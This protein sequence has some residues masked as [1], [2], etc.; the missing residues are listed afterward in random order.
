MISSSEFELTN[1]QEI[2][3]RYERGE[4]CSR[5][6]R[7]FGVS[8]ETIRKWLEKAGVERRTI[9]DRNRKYTYRHDA[10][11]HFEPVTAYW[12]GLLAADGSVSDRGLVSLELHSKD[13]ELVDG[14]A[15]FIQYTGPVIPRSCRRKS[16]LVSEMI[17]LRVTAPDIASQLLLWGVVPRKTYKAQ[18]ICLREDLECHY[19]RGLFDG[20]GCFH[21]RKNGGL[22]AKI[23]KHPTVIDGFRDWCWRTFREV[24]SLTRKSK[25]H[26]VQFGGNSVRLLWKALYSSDGPRLARKY[27]FLID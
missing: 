10:F 13:R 1:V 8:G 20:D 25:F 24:G 18:R 22:C 4:H 11:E 12:A 14:L 6:A 3:Q 2:I 19:Y 23:A 7:D 15:S 17:S 9:S 5:I 21:R 27:G 26:I 16:G